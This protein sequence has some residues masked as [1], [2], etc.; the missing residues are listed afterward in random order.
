MNDAP[1]SEAVLNHLVFFTLIDNSP[2]SVATLVEACKKYLSDHPGTVRFDVGTRV[3]DLEREVNDQEFDVALNIV[4]Q[5][6]ADHDRY[7]TSEKHVTFLEENKGNWKQSRVFD[8]YK[9]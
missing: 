2:A 7:Q 9:S 6:R 8:S 3:A 1:G 4:F 5:S